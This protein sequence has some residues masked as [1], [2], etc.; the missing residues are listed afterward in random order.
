M[1]T[2]ARNLFIMDSATRSNTPASNS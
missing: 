1:D 2:V